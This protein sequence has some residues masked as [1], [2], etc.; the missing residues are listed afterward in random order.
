MVPA[1]ARSGRRRLQCHRSEAADLAWTIGTSLLRD[2]AIVLIAYGAVIVVA[3]WL[4][5]RTRPARRLR[6]MM[7]FTLRERP[8]LAYGS[9]GL[10]I[11]LLVLWGPTGALRQPLP[12]LGFTALLAV[13]L[14]AIRRQAAREF[15]QARAGDARRVLTGRLSV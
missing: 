10:A 7:A 1:A 11:F 14:E 5:G 9:L 2:I 4:A 15:P 8:L 6:A 13:G 3:A 12:V